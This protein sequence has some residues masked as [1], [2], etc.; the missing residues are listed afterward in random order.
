[1]PLGS[2]TISL[3]L[4]GLLK[5]AYAKKLSSRKLIQHVIPEKLKENQ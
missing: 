4:C 3:D 2:E 5:L 1:M